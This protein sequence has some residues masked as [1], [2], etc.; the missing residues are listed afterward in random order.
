[1]IT[2]GRPTGR[3]TYFFRK[4]SMCST[5]F[6]RRA[7]ADWLHRSRINDELSSGWVRHWTITRGIIP[8]RASTKGH[9][10]GPDGGCMRRDNEVHRS[11]GNVFADIGVADA[12]ERLAKAELSRIIHQDITERGLKQ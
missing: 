12:E 3:L 5:S 4:W 9:L 7:D 1:M 6:K 11:S 10:N 2:V 8:V